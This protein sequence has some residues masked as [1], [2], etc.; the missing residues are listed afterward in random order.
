MIA[1]YIAGLFVQLS[2]FDYNYYEVAVVL[3]GIIGVSNMF[4]ICIT[5]TLSISIRKFFILLQLKVICMGY[6]LI[7]FA[8]FY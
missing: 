2:Y 5:K 4:I 3:V 1:I 7:M 8:G 6:H